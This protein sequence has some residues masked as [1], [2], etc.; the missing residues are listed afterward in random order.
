MDWYIKDS[1]GMYL[2]KL[3]WVHS[4]YD[5]ILIKDK[6][7]EDEVIRLAKDITFPKTDISVEI[8]M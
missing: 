6:F 4:K 3:G 5:A 7:D 8:K 2:T 1:R